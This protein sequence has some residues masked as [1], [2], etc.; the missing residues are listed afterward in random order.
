[1]NLYPD[2]AGCSGGFSVPGIVDGNQ[3]IYGNRKCNSIA[4][5]HSPNPQGTGCAAIGKN[6]FSLARY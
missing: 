3:R 5:N 4:G 2:I 1:M 6:T